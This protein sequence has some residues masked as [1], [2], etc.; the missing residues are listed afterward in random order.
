MTNHK[1]SNPDFPTKKKIFRGDIKADII[2]I[3]SSLNINIQD[4]LIK[5]SEHRIIINRTKIIIE[6]KKLGYSYADIGRQF[7]LTPQ[8]ILYAVKKKLK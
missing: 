4:V 7:G 8:A 1:Q 5:S 2:N 3:G 6:A